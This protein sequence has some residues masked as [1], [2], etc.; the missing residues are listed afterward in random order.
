MPDRA[1]ETVP[2]A[3]P[4]H[5]Q[6][7]VATFQS[8]YSQDTAGVMAFTTLSIVPTVDFPAIAERRLVGGLTGA[9]EG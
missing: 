4:V 9:V 5:P 1:G 2:P 7:G 3:R 8:Q 6:T